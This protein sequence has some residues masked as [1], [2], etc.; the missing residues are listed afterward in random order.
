MN[1]LISFIFWVLGGW[2]IGF[3]IGFVVKTIIM[4]SNPVDSA[5]G[6]PTPFAK[7]TGYVMMTIGSIVWLIELPL[8]G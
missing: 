1:I 7:K 8:W 2:W 5:F 4:S 3:C 6:D